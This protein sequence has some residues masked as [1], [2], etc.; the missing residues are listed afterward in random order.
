MLTGLMDHWVPSHDAI[1]RF[2]KTPFRTLK[3]H[4]EKLCDEVAI[5]NFTFY[6]KWYSNGVRSSLP[7]LHNCPDAMN[8]ITA[9]D[10]GRELIEFFHSRGMTVGAMLQNYMFDA[11]TFPP[12][13][14]L[15]PWKGI[16][17]CTGYAT[18]DDI[19]N[20]AWDGYP[21]VLSQMLEEQLRLFPGLDAVFLEFEG[22]GAAP[23]GNPLWQ[24][25]HAGGGAQAKI[26]AETR[27]FWETTGYPVTA[28][29]DPWLWTPAVQDILRRTLRSHL[30]AADRALTRAGFAGVR[31]VV[32]HAMGYEVPYVLDCLPDRNWWPLPWHYWGWDYSLADPEP[33]IRRQLDYCKGAFRD[34]VR[35][36]YKLC[37]IGNAT[38]PSK[39]FDCITEMVRLSEE[40]GAAGYLGMGDP[41]PTYGLRWHGA[42]EE[43]VAAARRLYRDELFPKR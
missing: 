16:Q 21:G 28:P 1:S 24:L 38:L 6:T 34:L 13:A 12:E 5:N 40:I 43:S 25:A 26:P 29:P 31:G 19:I 20:P 39:R 36:G 15:G 9:N 2:W 4:L 18:D 33:M 22:L 27:A 42:T 14:V 35:S 17:A 37:Y 10:W 41:I 3:P 23:A 11:G 30:T 32:Y 7:F 8:V